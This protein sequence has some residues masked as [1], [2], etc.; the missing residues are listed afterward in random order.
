MRKYKVQVTD[1]HS[2][3]TTASNPEEA[4]LKAWNSIK[5]SYTYG[6]RS[7]EEFNM[8]AKVE[9]VNRRVI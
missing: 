4:K 8:K 9:I 5:D 7:W 3:V 2:I 6:Y 1:H